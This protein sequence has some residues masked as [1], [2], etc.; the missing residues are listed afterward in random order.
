[1]KP[2]PF[3]IILKYKDNKHF[4][5]KFREY[6]KD[7]AMTNSYMSYSND[8]F[9]FAVRLANAWRY[10]KAIKERFDL[11]PQSPVWGQFDPSCNVKGY[12]FKDKAGYAV[13]AKRFNTATG[14]YNAIKAYND[15][16]ITS[17]YKLRTHNANTIYAMIARADDTDDYFMHAAVYKVIIDTAN[18]KITKVY[19]L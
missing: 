7:A 10:E 15:N 19:P 5:D 6:Y 12:D 18:H 17:F 13:E 16:D 9:C 11:T 1:M 8:I 3:E 2:M 14:L 4:A